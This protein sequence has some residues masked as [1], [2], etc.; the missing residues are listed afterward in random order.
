MSIPSVGQALVGQAA[1]VAH[2]TAVSLSGRFINL[3]QNRLVAGGA[4]TVS[5]AVGIV[6][7]FVCGL[8]LV[9]VLKPVTL[10]LFPRKMVKGHLSVTEGYVNFEK[11]VLLTT[12]AATFIALNVIVSKCLKLP[13][14]PLASAAISAG[15][16]ALGVAGYF[17]ARNVL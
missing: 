7:G 15:G 10:E 12:W 17:F 13:F 1:G 2:E 9:W 11:A 5:S 8:M 14:S 16:A 3:F 4:L 6:G